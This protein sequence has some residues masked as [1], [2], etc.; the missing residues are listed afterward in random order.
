MSFRFDTISS[1]LIG[2]QYALLLKT[3]IEQTKKIQK[4][5]EMDKTKFKFHAG[6]FG[7]SSKEEQ[8][9]LLQ[10]RGAKNT[11]KSIKSAIKI[12]NDYIQEKQLTP[13]DLMSDNELPEFFCNFY[14]DM[15]T[16]DNEI[17]GTGSM[18]SIRSS[19]NRWFQ[20][21]RSINIITDPKFTQA[22]M[23][24]KAVQAKTKRQG[25]GSTRHKI[26]ISG[27]DL[28]LLGNYFHV[29]YMNNPDPRI[30]QKNVLFN[31]I[32]YLCRRVQE[33]IYGMTKD[34]FEVVVEPS[35]NRCV[36]QI[37]DELDKNHRENDRENP[38]QGRM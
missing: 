18:K 14:P 10:E 32:Y 15:R 23:M 24:F 7:V 12:V 36:H 31:I 30:L 27:E 29:D 19:L 28:S 22:N 21:N 5:Y 8:D 38:N 3:Q 20:D 1:I 34:W 26:P 6:R 17:Y 16:K 2:L 13:L 11:A 9:L 4:N 35:G 37:R 25:K 33:N